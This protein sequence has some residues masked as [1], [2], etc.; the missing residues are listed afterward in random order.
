[1]IREYDDKGIILLLTH[2][3]KEAKSKQENK[4]LD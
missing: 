4:K 3:L 1:M 2:S